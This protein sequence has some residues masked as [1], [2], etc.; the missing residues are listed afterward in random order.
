[1]SSMV[2]NAQNAVNEGDS[3]V[4][5]WITGLAGSGKT[6]LAALLE[7]TLVNEGVTVARVDGDDFR[8]FHVPHLGY[9][10]T[11]RRECA[12]RLTQHCSHVS[13]AHA[14]TIVATISLFHDIHDM[15]R[16]LHPRYLEV[17]LD[18]G[19]TT[20]RRRRPLPEAE[21]PSWV[22]AGQAAE[23]PRRP[24]LR[25]RNEVEDDLPLNIQAMR[26]HLAK[27]LV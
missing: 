23:W 4:M 7:A 26:A 11:D 1:M 22:G 19:E 10:L 15:N 12:T 8:K 16:Q 25:L 20:L 27:H 6:R 3:G 17:L 24:H 14:V 18:V 13:R 2:A 9:S 5:V 21:A